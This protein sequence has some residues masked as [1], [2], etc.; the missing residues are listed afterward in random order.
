MMVTFNEISPP[1]TATTST[2]KIHGVVA[3][4]RRTATGGGITV[5]NG[6]MA[7]GGGILTG[8]PPATCRR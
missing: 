3:A 8:V 4:W 1:T 7:G 6:G 5:A 2:C